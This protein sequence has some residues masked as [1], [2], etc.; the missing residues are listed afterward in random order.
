M[1]RE[2]TPIER[3]A[4]YIV[5]MPLYSYQVAPAVAILESI[6][7]GYG[8]IITV[9]MSR[10]SGKN[11][12]SAML[13]AFLLYTREKGAIIKAAPT[14]NPQIINSTRRLKSMLASKF[15][16]KR[17]WTSYGQ[18]G[19]A[20]TPD[21]ESVKLHEGPFVQFFSADPESNVVGATAEIL[22]EIDEAQGILPEKF[23]TDFRPMASTTNATTVMWG[24]AWSDET[25]LARQIAVNRALEEKDGR[26]RHF[27]YD[28]KACGSVNPKYRKFVEGEIERLGID[29]QSVQTQYFLKSI[30]GAGYFL[31]GLQRSLLQ[32][33]H[34]WEDIPSEGYTYVA[35]IDIGGEERADPKNPEKVNNKRDSTVLTIGRVSYNQFQ[36]PQIEVV[37]QAWW[38]GMH[39]MTQY[40][41]ICDFTEKWNLR[42]IVIDATG[43]GESLGSLVLNK[44]GEDRVT[45]YKFSRPSKS[46]VG[47]SILEMVNSGRL[48]LYAQ[49]YSPRSV[50]DEM[51]SQVRRCRYELPAAN[52]INF[53]VDPSEGHD[54]FILSLGLLTQSLES[55]IQP[56]TPTTI[57]RPRRL[58]IDEGRWGF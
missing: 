53:Y 57:I 54:D 22:L 26:K 34:K 36:L 45:L 51:W 20:P 17:I 55:M 39:Y 48:K 27:Q 56:A 40:N 16:R 3:F 9:M 8:D 52:T 31:N 7:K 6:E 49:S 38:T 13:E 11:Q 41:A 15:L 23:D 12:T 33:T 50:Y 4:R 44:F 21:K 30:S 46:K 43:I 32:G 18:M 29:H 19:L 47:Y 37:H 14:F 35:G 58:Y 28:W 1:I 5:G 2:E 42:H 25:L 10:Q 24:T